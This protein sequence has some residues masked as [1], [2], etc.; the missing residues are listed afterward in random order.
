MSRRKGGVGERQIVNLLK[1]A[2]IDSKRISMLETGRIFKGDITVNDKRG[3][4]KFEQKVPKYMY[5]AL[6][7]EDY[8][9]SRSNRRPWL[10]T[11][12]LKD[13]VEL[14]KK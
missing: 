10:V 7:E 3:S 4:V 2:G 12:R 13:F 1:L 11:M 9:F 8:L 6:G 5:S 14:M